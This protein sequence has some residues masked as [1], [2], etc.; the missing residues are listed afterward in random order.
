MAEF[1]WKFASL[2]LRSLR[3]STNISQGSVAT[4]LMCD[5]I[6]T[7]RFS[8]KLLRSLSVKKLGK[9]VCI[10]QS[11]SQKNRVATFSGQIGIFIASLID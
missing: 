1:G 6:Y 7:Y 3:L 5:A 2:S 9:S 11:Y 8:I 4:R 10:W